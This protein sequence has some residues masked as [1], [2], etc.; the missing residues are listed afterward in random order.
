MYTIHADGELLHAPHLFSEGC[1]VVSPKLTVELNKAGSLEY[2]MPPN[3]ILYN[4]VSKLKTI[5]TVN[6]DNDEIFRGR[7]LHDEKDF[8][9]QRVTYCEGELAFL[10]DSIQRPYNFVNSTY[11][12][13]FKTFIGNH[14]SRVEDNKKFNVG[15]VTVDKAN[16]KFSYKGTR[17]STTIDEIT[18]VL[19]NVAGGYLKTYKIGSGRYIDWV[20]E[21]G[22]VSS[23]TIEFGRNLL[24]L[25]EHITAENVYTILIPL[26]KSRQDSNG[27]DL[28][29][30]TIAT[31]N[32]NKD[33]IENETA[34]SLFGRIEHSEEWSDISNETTLKNLGTEWLNKNIEMSAALTLK[35]VDLHLIDVDVAQIRLGDWVRVISL[36]HRIDKTFQCI[37]IVYDLASPDQTEYSFGI[38]LKG[39]TD[40]QVQDGKS[41]AGVQAAANAATQAAKDVTNIIANVPTGTISND[42]ITNVWNKYFSS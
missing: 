9:N 13:A 41:V 1:G 27:N 15:K 32:N 29:P 18:E 24:D 31:V 37:K 38:N 39:L 26:G 22:E 36:P 25:T 6:N 19:L 33:Y 34:I 40:K 17:Y 30:L 23:Q 4:K 5:I 35:A 21:S 7:I 42:S 14:N 11:E 10:L 16:E 28:G 3:H 2:T 12:T 8:Y 20:K